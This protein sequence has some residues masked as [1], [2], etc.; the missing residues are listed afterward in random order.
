VTAATVTL[1]AVPLVVEF[2]DDLIERIWLVHRVPHFLFFF[3][4]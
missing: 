3:L 2:G 1:D 4:L